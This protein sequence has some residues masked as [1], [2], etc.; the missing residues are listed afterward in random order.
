MDDVHWMSLM[1]RTGYKHRI[2]MMKDANINI[3][4]LHTH[5]SSP[6]FYDL[7]DEMGMMVWQD[8]P[9]HGSYSKSE[10]VRNDIKQIIAETMQQCRAHASVIGWTAWSEGDLTSSARNWQI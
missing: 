4:R 9:L 5:Q 2:Q 10:A 8:M 6:E 7:C 3:I 1:D